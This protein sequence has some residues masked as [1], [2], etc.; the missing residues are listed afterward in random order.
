MS[1]HIIEYHVNNTCTHVHAVT[2][3]FRMEIC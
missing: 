2:L 1:K 3:T